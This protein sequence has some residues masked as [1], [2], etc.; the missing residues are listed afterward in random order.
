MY[1]SRLDMITSSLKRAKQPRHYL[2]EKRLF[3]VAE[4]Y[5]MTLR[6]LFLC[7]DP[8][9]RDQEGLLPRRLPFHWL[10]PIIGFLLSISSLKN[11]A[12][13]HL[14]SRSILLLPLLTER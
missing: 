5:V 7:K 4:L 9:E 12:W 11:K 8:F 3:E 14:S 2:L 6:F 13:Q 1:Q 10:G